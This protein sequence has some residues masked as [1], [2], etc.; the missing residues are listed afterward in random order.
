LQHAPYSFR[1]VTRVNGALDYITSQ[2][3]PTGLPVEIEDGKFINWIVIHCLPGLYGPDS[4][5]SVNLDDYD[6]ASQM[7]F[8][9]EEFPVRLPKGVSLQGTSALDTIFDGRGLDVPI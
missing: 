4:T 3:A 1:T 9:G 8:N 5:L 7:R 6:S 2:I